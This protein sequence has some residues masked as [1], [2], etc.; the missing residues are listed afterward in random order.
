M[1]KHVITPAR[2]DSLAAC[3]EMM[4]MMVM[5]LMVIMTKMRM[6]GEVRMLTM[7][8]MMMMM[9]MMV[10]LVEAPWCTMLPVV[11][12]G[13]RRHS[14]T[15]TSEVGKPLQTLT[16]NIPSTANPYI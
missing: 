3:E 4:F 5:M 8:V 1:H 10:V 16:L 15:K 12:T 13:Q 14:R 2:P 6:G 9:M 7:T 11:V